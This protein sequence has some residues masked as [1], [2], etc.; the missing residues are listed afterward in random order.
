[1]CKQGK[2]GGADAVLVS[3]A[4]ATD[5]TATILRALTAFAGQVLLCSH[6]LSRPAVRGEVLRQS[7]VLC[8]GAG[9]PL[10]LP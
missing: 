8:G 10:R 4:A 3:A 6:R 1:M 5:V 2:H 7:S 9:F